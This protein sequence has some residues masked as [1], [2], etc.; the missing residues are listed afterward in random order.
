MWTSSADCVIKRALLND[1]DQGCEFSGNGISHCSQG[2]CT[3]ENQ[4]KTDET[5]VDW[6]WSAIIYYCTV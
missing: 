1:Q 4:S 5:L 6:S 3:K 2:A